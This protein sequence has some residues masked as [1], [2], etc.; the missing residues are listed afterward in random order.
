MSNIS[1]IVKY[2]TEY[3]NRIIRVYDRATGE[4]LLNTNSD[5]NGIFSI[6]NLSNKTVYIVC[7]D[8]DINE[9]LNALIY[10]NIII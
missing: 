10:D 3:A 5:N 7:L 8:D 1:G 4:L 6:N 9:E 2:K